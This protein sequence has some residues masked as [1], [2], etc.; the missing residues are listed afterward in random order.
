VFGLSGRIINF[1]SSVVALQP[2]YGAYAAT[3]A[4]AEA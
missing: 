2:I 1:S 3:K 4:G